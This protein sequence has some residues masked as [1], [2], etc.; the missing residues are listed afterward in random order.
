MKRYLSLVAI[1]AII[2]SGCLPDSKVTAPDTTAPT[3][4][5]INDI[6]GTVTTETPIFSFSSDEA[7][8][9]NWVGS[10]DSSVKN[11]DTGSNSITL[12]TLANGSYSD[13]ALTVTDASGNTSVLLNI[14]YFTVDAILT[15]V[16]LIAWVGSN[17]TQ[18]QLP[19]NIDGFEFYRTTEI[20]CDL[21]NYASCNDGQMDILNGSLITD[22]A[23]T[24]TQS[25]YYVLKKA[26][27]NSNTF[28]ASF[29]LPAFSGRYNHQS[30]V[31][32]NKMWVIG[33]D[34]GSSK[35]DV[36]SSSDG[37]SWVQVTSSAS[38][39]K[40]Y[41]H[42]S[43]VFNDR[44]WVLGG[45]SPAGYNLSDV[46][47]SSD[48]INWTQHA[49]PSYAARQFHQCLVFNDKLWVIGGFT[50][51][52]NA[53]DV[54]STSDGDTWTQV[55]A[56]AAFSARRMHQSVVFKNKM[57][58]IG[59]N[60]GSA[61]KNDVWSSSDGINWN[62]ATASAGFSG[63]EGHR[64][65]VFDNKIWVFGGYSTANNGTNFDD[66]W[67]SSDGIDWTQEM[68]NAGFSSPTFS[69][70]LTFNNKLWLIGGHDKNFNRTKE[71]WS[72]ESNIDWRQGFTGT[73]TFP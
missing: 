6:T 66:V 34:D 49:T 2:F 21:A 43:V 64:S 12:N 41:G 3:L 62:Q 8:T 5:I 27:T 71:V 11:V 36:W 16:S 19:S 61:Y 52:G 46:W 25:A 60:D 13:C 31:F 35:N 56:S 22:T 18:V 29:E 14:G 7:G 30:V 59:G 48:G 37:I 58:L 26:G 24:L 38:F 28:T 33:G 50:G 39:G 40:R 4:N 57:W 53:S 23:F 20:N 42:Q 51:P 47:S 9:I 73:I 63:R 67:Y 69:Q 15:E 68:S 10:C 17:D 72:T 45:Y 54:W 65:A 70:S 32:K 55:T 44:I 1:S